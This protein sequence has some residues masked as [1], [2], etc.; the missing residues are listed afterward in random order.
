MGKLSIWR[1]SIATG[2]ATGL[3]TL[4]FTLPAVSAEVVDSILA[5]VNDEIVTQSDVA[6]FEN[7]LKTGGLVDDQLVPDETVRQSLLKDRELL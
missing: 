4:L 6:D 1:G 5:I 2:L 3:A 7:R